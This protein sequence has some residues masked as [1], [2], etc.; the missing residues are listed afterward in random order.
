M[1]DRRYRGGGDARSTAEAAF[2]KVTAPAPPVEAEPKPK[3]APIPGAREM[4]TLRIER[5][6]LEKFQAD[7][8]GWQDRMNV[9]LRKAVGL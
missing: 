6:V 7:G 1:S 5:D 9:A 2:R 3:A 8:P 4:V